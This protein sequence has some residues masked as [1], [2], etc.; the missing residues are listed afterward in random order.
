MSWLDQLTFDDRGLVPVVA[1]DALSGD[2][3]MLAYADREALAR[4]MRTRAAHYWSRSRGEIWEKGATSGNRQ[5]VLDLRVDCDGDAVLYLVRP[6]GPAC[7]TLE[8]S[9][10]YRA[11]AE[12]GVGPAPLAGGILSRLEEVVRHRDEARPEGSYTSYLFASGLDKVLKKLGEETTETIVAA[13][14]GDPGELRAEVAD[15]LFHLLVLLRS[16]GLPL[17]AVWEELDHRFGGETRVPPAGRER[18]PSS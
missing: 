9:C 7:H 4:T 3:L 10:F 6:A 12:E 16:S 14:N 8:P 15:L 2:V 5:E 11:A 13:K 1:Q 17:R 18:H